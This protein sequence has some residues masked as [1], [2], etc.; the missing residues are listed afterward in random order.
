MK[1]CHFKNPFWVAHPFKAFQDSNTS[2][3]CN[4]NCFTPSSFE[5]PIFNFLRFLAN[6]L[7]G[8]LWQIGFWIGHMFFCW[9]YRWQS[10]DGT[11]S[12]MWWTIRVSQFVKAPCP[13]GV[14]LPC[15][16][17]LIQIIESLPW[18]HD[19]LGSFPF[20]WKKTNSPCTIFT[21]RTK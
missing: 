2:S 13:N 16:R 3:H 1:F 18:S 10:E 21:I 12:L 20:L 9:C 17:Q 19:V 5:L 7:L 11:K 6:G 4:V 14:V 8:F 15:A